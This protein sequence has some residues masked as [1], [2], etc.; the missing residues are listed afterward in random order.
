MTVTVK[1]KTKNPLVVPQAVRRQ[2]GH[3]N[4]QDLEFRVS[5]GV[6]TILPK[7]LAADDEYTPAERRAIDRGIAQSE[8]QY[9]ADK[10]YGPFDTAAEAIA[11][12][13]AHLRQRRATAKKLK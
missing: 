3:R 13:N 4:G 10:S 11:S 7:L 8:K 9:A 5:G 2:A 12:I 6:I 1:N